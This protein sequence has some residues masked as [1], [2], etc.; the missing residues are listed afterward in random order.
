MEIASLFAMALLGS[1]LLALSLIDIRTH[2][3][4][5]IL[6]LPLAAAGL[7]L[8]F[9]AEGGLPFELRLIGLA[10]GFAALWAIAALFRRLRGCDGLGL[11]DAKLLGA[12]GAWLGPLALA[13]VVLIAA[14]AALLAVGGAVL[15]GHKVTARTAIPFGPFLCLGFFTLW[16]AQQ[17]G[18]SFP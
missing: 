1:T 14:S 12:A 17:F 11:G 10:I 2:R 5:D 6:T 18:W 16:I 9:W 3:L 7:S 15:A 8:Q 13:P 4:P